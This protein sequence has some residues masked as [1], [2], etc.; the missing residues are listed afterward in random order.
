[1]DLF[2]EIDESQSLELAEGVMLLRGFALSEHATM[3]C[4]WHNVV[5]LAPFRH[6][7]TPGGFT[8]SVAMTNCGEL[9]WVTDKKG[10][11]YDA[12]DPVTG[13]PWPAMPASFMALARAAAKLAGYSE[14][15]PDACLINR[16]QVGAR[17]SLHQDKNERDFTQPIVSVSLGVS[18]VFQLGGFERVDKAV[19]LPL[20]HGDVLVWGGVSR[21]RYHGVL[22]LKVS[23]HPAFGEYRINLTFRKAG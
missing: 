19:K 20:Y 1:M 18:A 17:M 5:A 2:D 11:R 15:T 12:L 3:L 23:H 21:L 10:Y 9:G 13:K 7:V 14:F 4:D 16:Y 22:P 8:M 6:M